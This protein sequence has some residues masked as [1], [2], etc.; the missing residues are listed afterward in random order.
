MS[1]DLTEVR[2]EYFEN[3]P[4]HVE[5]EVFE[6]PE[7][8]AEDKP[9]EIKPWD[10]ERI[11]VSTK[12][13]S[14]RHVLDLIQEDDLDLAPDFQ[15]NRVWSSHQKSRL[16]ESILLQ[17]PL[18]AFYFA[19][20]PDGMLRAVDGL[21]RLSTVYSF[22]RGGDDAFTLRGM[23]YLHKWDGVTFAD[24]PA[25]LRRR[26]HNTQIV[27]HVIDPTT[28][29]AVKY[30]IFRRINTGGTPLNSQE[31]R[32]CMAKPRSRDFLKRC[33]A[34]EAFQGA[35]QGDLKDHIR[36]ADREIVLRYLA[37]RRFDVDGYAEI[38]SMDSFLDRM[39]G[40]LE[41]PGLMPDEKLEELFDNFELAMALCRDTLGEYAFRKFSSGRKNPINRPLFESWSIAIGEAGSRVLDC[42]EELVER[43]RDLESSDTVYLDS[44]TTS[45]G[46]SRRVR[47]RFERVRSEVRAVLRG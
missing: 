44:I 5:V 20:D 42:S 40:D 10:P 21:Q 25:P 46:G 15:R 34:S 27:V 2:E 9:S 7:G 4:T 22:V 13:F 8:T 38:G 32:H 19:E 36:M 6:D 45:T 24:L 28:P 3:M 43:A 14:L 26:L 29:P 35:T 12:Q 47:T 41:D 23:E 18:P 31:I 17:I 37:F 33:A 16:I 30:E 39:S 1:S 11:R